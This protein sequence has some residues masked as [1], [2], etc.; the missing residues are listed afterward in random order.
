METE[1]EAETVDG[2]TVSTSLV[3]CYI[4]EQWWMLRKSGVLC[5]R[6][7]AGKSFAKMSVSET[8]DIQ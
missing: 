5:V 4:L 3:D 6:T 8:S 2:I 7:C 1:V